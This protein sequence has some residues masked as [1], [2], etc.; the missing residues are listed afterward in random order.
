[1]KVVI[2]GGR[3]VRKDI[4]Y[5][6][7]GVCMGA[8]MKRGIQ[9]TEIISG[10]ARGVDTYA[11]EIA[12]QYGFPFTVIPA[13]WKKHGKKAGYLRNAQMAEAGDA[14]IAIWDGQ[15]PGTKMMIEIAER[16]GMPVEI[17]RTDRFEGV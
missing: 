9:I 8:F 5:F 2:A 16:K 17:Y 4:A 14:L 7:I 1:M 10:G 12:G 6:G 11:V 15:S 13:D 3:E